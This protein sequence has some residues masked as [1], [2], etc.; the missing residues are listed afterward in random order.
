[1]GVD[2]CGAP[3]LHQALL[4]LSGQGKVVGVS[5]KRRGVIRVESQR[6]LESL[7]CPGPVPGEQPD[8]GQRRMPG[9]I[10]RVQLQGSQG[11]SSRLHHVLPGRPATVVGGEQ[12]GAGHA[13]PGPR[14]TWIR[15]DRLLKAPQRLEK[16]LSGET[17]HRID[18]SQVEVSGS[19]VDRA[20]VGKPHFRLR[21]QGNIDFAAYGPGDLPQQGQQ[22]LYLAIVGLRPQVPVGFAVDQLGRDL[23]P[24]AAPHHPALDQGVDTQFPRDLR[25]G[26][27][28]V[29]VPH[30]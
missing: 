3:D 23:D 11:G 17:V 9:K 8:P 2:A 29:P 20:G 13:A 18:R 1:M 7:A 28:A 6:L 21:T 10:L 27:V 25:G 4:G 26:L 15:R 22:V 16:F 5:M 19:G 14:E 24:V 30:S 12:M